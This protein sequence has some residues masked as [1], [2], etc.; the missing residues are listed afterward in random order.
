MLNDIFA[1]SCQGD[2]EKMEEALLVLEKVEKR[3]LNLN[4]VVSP[5]YTVKIRNSAEQEFKNK[6]V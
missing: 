3:G 1:A 6:I 2:K 5:G 4:N